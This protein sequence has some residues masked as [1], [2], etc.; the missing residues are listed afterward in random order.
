M[1]KILVSII[2]LTTMFSC[3]TIST[4]ISKYNVKEITS[5]ASKYVKERNGELIEYKDAKIIKRGYG[6]WYVT[7]Y[8]VDKI[9]NLNI[10]EDGE[11]VKYSIENYVK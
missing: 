11:I 1:R 6:M 7:L 9:Y 10:N 5:F 3:Y 4:P 2:F 8:G